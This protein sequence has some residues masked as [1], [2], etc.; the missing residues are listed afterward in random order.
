MEAL[1]KPTFDMRLYTPADYAF[2][3]ALWTAQKWTPVPEDMLPETGAVISI[4]GKDV[5]AGFIY[6]SNSKTCWLEWLI[7]DPTSDKETRSEGLDACI[8][9]LL[10]LAS[11]HGAKYVI[12][13]VMHPKLLPRLEKHGFI[14]TDENMTNMVRIL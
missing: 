11:M 5:C 14:K 3:K 2:V 1:K 9:F 10:N 4:D 6:L 12:M 8:S 7:A 13:S